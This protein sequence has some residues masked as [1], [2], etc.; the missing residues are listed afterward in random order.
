M[1]TKKGTKKLQRPNRALTIVSFGFVLVALPV[2]ILISFYAY[3]LV[4]LGT[5][6]ITIAK[7]IAI[8]VLMV[9]SLGFVLLNRR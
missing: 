7:G 3:S 1:S 4:F 9:G 2:F 6:A 8:L 5:D